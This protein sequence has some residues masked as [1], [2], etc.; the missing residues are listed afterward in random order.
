[1]Y[2]LHVAKLHVAHIHIDLL[3]YISAMPSQLV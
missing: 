3:E 1:V 2:L